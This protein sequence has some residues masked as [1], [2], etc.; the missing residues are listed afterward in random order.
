MIQGK[1]GHCKEGLK[2]DYVAIRNGYD[3]QIRLLGLSCR[4]S[5]C[6][7]RVPA[8]AY[9]G[10]PPP[11]TKETNPSLPSPG[12]ALPLRFLAAAAAACKERDGWSAAN[13]PQRLLA[14]GMHAFNRPL[15]AILACTP[16]LTQAPVTLHVEVVEGHAAIRGA[17]GVIDEQRE[18][19]YIGH[20]TLV[21]GP[22]PA[23]APLDSAI[24]V[25]IL[26]CTLTRSEVVRC[27]TTG[28]LV[29]PDESG[30]QCPTWQID[31]QVHGIIITAFPDH[32]GSIR[33]SIS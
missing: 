31:W 25:Q 27:T 29:C 24:C 13:A 18:V 8:D 11:E 21:Y 19:L 14:I 1:P 22:G 26:E 2:G 32:C 23:L 4:C 28:L 20:K 15:H 10:H 12:S 17:E 5:L 30:K 9:V 7:R 3:S 6:G 16:S 33:T